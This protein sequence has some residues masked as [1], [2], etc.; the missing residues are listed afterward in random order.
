MKLLQDIKIRMKWDGRTGHYSKDIKD[1][2]VSDRRKC[3]F[4]LTVNVVESFDE[5]TY[6]LFSIDVSDL[7]VF[8]RDNNYIP[9]STADYRKLTNLII[10][11]VTW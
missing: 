6:D 4:H 9:M 5:E 2:M 11:R 7:K 8:D 1:V 10:D 3:D